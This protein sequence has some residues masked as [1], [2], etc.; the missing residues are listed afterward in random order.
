MIVRTMTGACLG[1]KGIFRRGRN[2][3]LHRGVLASV[4][5]K[6]KRIN[7]LI[8][9]VTIENQMNLREDHSLTDFVP[10]FVVYSVENLDSV[11]LSANS[12][13]YLTA[14]PACIPYRNSS[15]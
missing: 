13:E 10:D 8:H 11:I 5:I 9:L 12:I 2:H 14:F 1:L 4:D 3:L 7:L 6:A 15:S